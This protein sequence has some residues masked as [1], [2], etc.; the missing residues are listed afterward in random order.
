MEIARFYVDAQRSFVALCETLSDDEWAMPVPCNPGWTV[1]DVLSHVVGVTDDVA[2]GRLEGAATDPWTDAQVERWRDTPW[3]T[4]VTQWNEQVGGVAEL[5]EAVREF[6][7]PFDC[8]SHEHDVRHAINRPGN[9]DS[10]L[11]GV[12]AHGF[13]RASLGRPVSVELVDADSLSL[14]GNG[15]PIVLRGLT[16]FE[17]VRARLGRRS[18]AQV[19]AFDWSEQPTDEML[20]AFFLFGPNQLDII[21]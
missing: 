9:R 20:A 18:A 1:R 10:E 12:I 13:G 4:L 15:A 21:E 5:L 14:T 16:Q 7:P 6:R 19:R 2:N 17:L 8:H 11:I 3:R